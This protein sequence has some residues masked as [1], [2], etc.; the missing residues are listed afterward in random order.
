MIQTVTQ[1]LRITEIGKQK[2]K[3]GFGTQGPAGPA[4]GELR[5]A[6]ASQAV[7]ADRLVYVDAAGGIAHADQSVTAHA[8][9]Y[10]GITVQAGGAGN[11]ISVRT[12]GFHT[13]NGWSWSPGD[14]IFLGSNGL[15]TATPPNTGA[16]L[17]IG[18]ATNATTILLKDEQ[19]L[20]R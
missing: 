20:I 2:I 8:L 4:G 9:S 17:I 6:I 15:A 12:E 18:V 19:P 1:T 16:L 10:L 5:S 3:I 11:V 14:V 13:F 7:G